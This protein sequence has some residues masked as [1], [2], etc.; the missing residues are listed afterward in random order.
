MMEVGTYAASESLPA[1]VDIDKIITRHAAIVGSTG[2]GKSN[3]VAKLLRS[4]ADTSFPNASVL[5]IDPHGEYGS[6]L[7]GKARVFSIGNVKHPLV[8]PYW[9]LSFDE[10][11][12]FLVDRKSASETPQDAILRDRITSSKKT[13]C[14]KLKTGLVDENKITADS[15]IPFNLKEIWFG[16][17]LNEHATLRTK[18]NWDNIAYKKDKS[19]IEIRGEEEKMIPPQFE[20]PGPGSSSPFKSTRAVGLTSYLNKILGRFKDSRF[21]FLLNPGEYNGCNSDLNDLLASWINHEQSITVIDLGGIPPEVIDLVVGVVTR[22]LFESM[23]WGS[24]LPGIGKQR[25]LLIIYEEAHSYLPRGSNSQFIAGY[26]GRVVR[27]IFKEGRKYG[28]GAVVVSQR[29][30]ELDETILSQ[31]G[32]YF[33]L[34]LSNSEDQGIIRAT[35]PDSLG[36]LIDLLPALRTGEALVLGE[37]V[38]IPSRIRFPLVEPRPTSNDPEPSKCWRENRT[39]N[40]PYEKA[41]SYWRIQKKY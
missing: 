30:S 19:G 29:P 20:P 13:F 31:C 4:I 22:I 35:V 15:P 28:V 11:A 16:L 3:T 5:V 17:Y 25:P 1:K 18:D 2:S 38:Q 23:F 10:L 34:R 24:D 36:G 8:I 27:R 7:Q 6:A 37:A 32:T 21:D 26:A 12:W 39:N 9:A 40:P 14:D 33:T 41:I